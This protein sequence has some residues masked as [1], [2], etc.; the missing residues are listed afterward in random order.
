MTRG[1]RRCDGCKSS[2]RRNGMSDGYGFG[3]GD[4]SALA[5]RARRAIARKLSTT[6]LAGAEGVGDMSLHSICECAGH[7]R[8]KVFEE[9]VREGEPE[10]LALELEIN[11]PQNSVRL[12]S[13]RGTLAEFEEL[14][15]LACR[16][17]RPDGDRLA[18][19]LAGH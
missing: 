4:R 7:H 3:G 10:R 1:V 14:L 15:T 5:D 9:P 11:C 6:A 19:S 17:L 8:L 18:G 2:S 12:N 13:R 16:L